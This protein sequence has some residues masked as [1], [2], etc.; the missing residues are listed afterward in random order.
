VAL[1]NKEGNQKDGSVH[2]GNNT[3]DESHVMVVFDVYLRELAVVLH[4]DP[5]WIG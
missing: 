4:I 1:V 2:N 3:V 5:S